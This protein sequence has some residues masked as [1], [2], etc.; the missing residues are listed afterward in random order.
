MEGELGP[1]SAS[2]LHDITGSVA[3]TN[4]HLGG[5]STD[6]PTDQ[7][8]SRLVWWTDFQSAYSRRHVAQN[9]CAKVIK[10]FHI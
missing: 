1:L 2:T 4:G 9:N 7:E 10:S 6:P 3:L 5:G 8:L